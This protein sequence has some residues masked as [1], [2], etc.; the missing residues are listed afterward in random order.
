MKK[1]LIILIIFTSISAAG[2]Y[3]LLFTQPGNNLLKP[4]LQSKIS[5][6]I[7]MPVEIEDFTLRTSFIKLYLN[8]PSALN[9]KL[10]SKFTI[11]GKD[12]DG[13]ININ[14]LDFT[15]LKKF[16]NRILKGKCNVNANFKGNVEGKLHVDISTDIFKGDTR[17]KIT[18]NGKKLDKLFYEAKKLKIDEILYFLNIKKYASGVIDSFGKFDM[19]AQKGNAKTL[20]AGNLSSPLMK[21]DF[22][23]DLP[24]TKFKGEIIKKLSDNKLGILANIYTT[25]GNLFL[26]KTY[27]NLKN[28]SLVSHYLLK[29]DNLAIFNKMTN[30]NLQGKASVN[31]NLKFKEKNDI[32]TKGIAK[33]NKNSFDYV[34]TYPELVVTCKR[35]DSI[36]ILKT[37]SMPR[38]FKTYADIKLNYSV[39]NKTGKLKVTFAEGILQNIRL[40]NIIKKI[41]GID[42]S[43]EVYRN[44]Y[45]T[46]DIDDKILNSVFEL[47]SKNSVISSK[48]TILNIDKSTIDSEINIEVIGIPLKIFL[49]GNMKKPDV[50]TDFSE[51][52]KAKFKKLPNVKELNKI[53]DLKNI[54]KN[55]KKGL[56]KDLNK[57]IKDIKKGFK[58]FF[59]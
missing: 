54:K 27:L 51:V 15:K 33:I 40:F 25:L 44:G 23:I 3:C 13:K 12:V 59:K 17:A 52:L 2:A 31:G 29:V 16:T 45:L 5:E 38:I 37:L 42:L 1:F 4:Y 39:T 8:S 34:L 49:T 26:D 11:L 21:K 43:L 41:T 20:F 19:V 53:N 47:K 46:T 18:D 48:K 58:S 55:L 50:K 10:V 22:N 14:I 7:G 36:D 57:N 32:Y 6:K 24:G 30:Q 56:G 9:V 35:F 28:S